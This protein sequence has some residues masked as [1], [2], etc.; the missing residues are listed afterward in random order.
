MSKSPETLEPIF[1][2]FQ[3]ELEAIGCDQMLVAAIDE[4]NVDRVR[5][6]SA[7]H[8]SSCL[9]NMLGGFIQQLEPNDF[10]RLMMGMATAP[11]FAKA[12][13]TAVKSEIVKR[14][15]PDGPAPNPIGPEFPTRP[16]RCRS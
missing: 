5:A 3:R 7:H 15:N 6:F 1:R 12:R 4:D 13:G 9:L 2:R 16:P 11:E 14:P 10:A 8:C